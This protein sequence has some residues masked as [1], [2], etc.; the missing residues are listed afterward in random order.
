MNHSQ[1]ADADD[2][3]PRSEQRPALAGAPASRELW[4]VDWRAA[5][6]RRLTQD[7]IELRCSDIERALPFV[8]AHYGA[9]FEED[10]ASN[11]FFSEPFDGA[12]LRYYRQADVFEMVDRGE[13]VGVAIGG[14]SDW[15]TYYLR[16]MGVLP[17]HQGRQLPR[18][19]FPFMFEVLSGAGVRRFEL[20][21]SPSNM[22][23]IQV[24]TRMRFNVTGQTLSDR[25]GAL[26]R[27]TKFL[28]QGAEDVFLDS[29]CTGI[30]Y[31]TRDRADRQSK[32]G[33]NR[34]EEVCS[35]MRLTDDV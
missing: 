22:A 20:D 3:E 16:T 5:L 6:P 7:G 17:S 11:R 33:G 9:I 24:L 4:G 2:E 18:C 19:I 35:S 25:W 13:T 12:K 21:T 30:R 27:L 32:R 8:A 15:S 23:T 14:P 34:E 29:F 1:P 10:P 28:D 26:L 31:Q